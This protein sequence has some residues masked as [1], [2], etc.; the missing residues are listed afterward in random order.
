MASTR[1]TKEH[2]WI[3]IEGDVATVGITAHAAEQLGDVVF[4]EV[5]EPFV[6]TR[7]ITRGPADGNVTV[8]DWTVVAGIPSPGNQSQLVACGEEVSVNVAG[9]P[10]TTDDGTAKLA[11]GGASE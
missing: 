3:S 9:W 8:G 1:F 6:A 7:T 2:E 10:A 4:V 11:C 5:P